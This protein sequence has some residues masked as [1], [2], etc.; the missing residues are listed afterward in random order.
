MYAV[1]FWGL[2]SKTMAAAKMEAEVTALLIDLE[3]GWGYYESGSCPSIIIQ[4]LKLYPA[5]S[6]SSP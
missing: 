1:K 5:I 6:I 3:A 4:A 2:A